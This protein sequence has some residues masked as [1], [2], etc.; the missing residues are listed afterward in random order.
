MSHFTHV[1]SV[2]REFMRHS[3]VGGEP[4]KHDADTDFCC[5]YFRSHTDDLH[6][7]EI[8][9]LSPRSE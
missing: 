8:A 5:A 3:G 6:A 4:E 1:L 9:Q 7:A 2:K